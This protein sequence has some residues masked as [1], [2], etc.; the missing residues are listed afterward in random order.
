MRLWRNQKGI[1]T[2]GLLWHHRFPT[3]HCNHCKIE[4][5]FIC[6][7]LKK[8]IAMLVLTQQRKYS[9]CGFLVF[10]LQIE[11]MK[12]HIKFSHRNIP[13]MPVRGKYVHPTERHVCL[14]KEKK[15]P[16]ILSKLVSL[17]V[18]RVWE[19][20]LN[21]LTGCQFVEPT[22]GK[23]LLSLMEEYNLKRLLPLCLPELY[24]QIQF[25]RKLWTRWNLQ[26]WITMGR[27]SFSS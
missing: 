25:C 6:V 2:V 5:Y 17:E 16:S 10:F 20:G 18:K 21:F 27:G 26:N 19:R 13:L 7:T 14:L 15:N 9:L 8:K 11:K 23:K 24:L 3:M 22:R 4:N 12:F 1:Q